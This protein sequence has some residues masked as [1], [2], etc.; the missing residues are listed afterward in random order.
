MTDVTWLRQAFNWAERQRERSGLADK[1]ILI[2][3]LAGWRDESIKVFN[4]RKAA[5]WRG[6][7][8]LKERGEEF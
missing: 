7:S 1:K 2:A 5:S 8:P 3:L 6:A 4:L